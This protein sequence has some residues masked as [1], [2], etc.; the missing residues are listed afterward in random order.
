MIL[1]K[2][3]TIHAARKLEKLADGH[4]CRELHGHTFYITLTVKGKLDPSN[5]FVIDYFEMDTI[6]K[7]NIMDIADHKY[8]NDILDSNNPSNELFA[9]WIWENL[10][11]ELPGLHKV[12]VGESDTTGVIYM[13]KDE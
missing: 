13:G 10:V 3:Y 9:I 4:P 2:R 12:E 11:A 1:Y 5:D 7:K 6:F 8:L